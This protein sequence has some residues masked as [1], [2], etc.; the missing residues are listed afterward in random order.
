[1]CAATDED[2]DGTAPDADRTEGGRGPI[3]VHAWIEGRVQGVFYRANA[4]RIAVELGVSG[5]VR[6][7][8]DGR[9]EAWAEGS[10]R[11][12]ETFLAWL[13]VGPPEARVEGVQHQ[14][15]APHDLHGFRIRRG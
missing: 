11:A 2:E 1:M 14:W 9:V 12:V 6:N 7:L 4:Q 5:W 8:P 13:R 10:T 15:D 3:A